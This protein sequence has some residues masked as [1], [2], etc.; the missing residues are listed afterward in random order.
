MLACILREM[1]GQPKAK[2]EDRTSLLVG[3]G[4]T[5]LLTLGVVTVFGDAIAA[6]FAPPPSPS[7]SATPQAVAA[8]SSTASS[9]G[10]GG[11]S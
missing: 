3:V 10:G 4:M 7:P 11:K 2:R 1:T 6:V 8:P 9:D 5:A